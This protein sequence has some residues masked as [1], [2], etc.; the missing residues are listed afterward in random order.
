[1]ALVGQVGVKFTGDTAE[2]TAATARVKS[3]N[4]AVEASAKKVGATNPFLSLT[5]SIKD[6]QKELKSS[7]IAQTLKLFAGGGAIGLFAHGLNEAANAAAALGK[8]L[9]DG[10]TKTESIVAAAYE[11]PITGAVL[12]IGD[13]LLGTENPAELLAKVKA[14]KAEI[15]ATAKGQMQASDKKLD[16][17]F[18]IKLQDPKLHDDY[19]RQH[20]VATEAIVAQIGLNRKLSA[21]IQAE[22]EKELELSTQI[23]DVEAAR[24]SEF[25]QGHL[26]EADML[27]VKAGLL[28]RTLDITKETFV[29]E[30]QLIELEKKNAAADAQ[31]KFED[32]LLKSLQ[33]NMHN[34]IHEPAKVAEGLLAQ[35][36]PSLVFAGKGVAKFFDSWDEGVEHAKSADEAIKESVMNRLEAAG[37]LGNEQAK[38]AA[39]QLKIEMQIAAQRDKLQR[40]A[41]DNKL[42]DDVRKSALDEIDRLPALKAALLEGVA[43]ST[44]KFAAAAPQMSAQ[45]TTNSPDASIP[46]GLL[47]NSQK[48]TAALGKLID[49]V[50]KGWGTIVT[51]GQ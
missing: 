34:L 39:A 49:A 31:N 37:A 7:G 51:I 16:L 28:Q 24:K 26:I 23:K 21:A 11:I 22:S 48:Q 25:V 10:L 4:A 20:P 12:K 19:A 45:F 6:M 13:A 50:N 43:S 18:D 33:G 9:G 17:G 46:K 29:K 44:V 38:Q 3:E 30:K 42:P 32:G 2:Y 27:K 40:I 8:N 1:M 41:T 5:H 36:S 15:Y 14:L 35:I 47:D